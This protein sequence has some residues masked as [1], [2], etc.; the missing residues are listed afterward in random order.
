MISPRTLSRGHIGVV[1]VVVAAVVLIGL[2]GWRAWVAFHK[3][4]TA[5]NQSTASTQDLKATPEVK[6]TG[7]LKV[8]D[9]DL[10]NLNTDSSDQ[11]DLS[12]QLNY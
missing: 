11:T 5:T 4:D 8:L 9:Q 6:S 10:G 1:L 12:A 7:D 3:D 2:L